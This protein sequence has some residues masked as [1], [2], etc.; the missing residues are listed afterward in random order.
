MQND[1]IEEP[2]LNLRFVI[3]ATGKKILE[4]EFVR[5]RYDLQEGVLTP[6]PCGYIWREVPL[7]EDE[8]S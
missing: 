6:D 4:Q 3:K 2:T 1:V 7:V 8:D 5:T